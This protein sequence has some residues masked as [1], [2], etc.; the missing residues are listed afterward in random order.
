MRLSRDRQIASASVRLGRIFKARAR[1]DVSPAGLLATG[2]LVCG[3]VL[4]GTVLAVVRRRLPA[5]PPPD[6]DLDG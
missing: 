5:L 2:A 1:V 6:G 3:I 4:S